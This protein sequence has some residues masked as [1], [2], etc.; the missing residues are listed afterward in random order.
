M[1]T[2]AIPTGYLLPGALRLLG[3]AGLARTSES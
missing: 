1:I 3:A 2:I